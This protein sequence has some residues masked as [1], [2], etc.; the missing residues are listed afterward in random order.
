MS[1]KDNCSGTTDH[2]TLCEWQYIVGTFVPSGVTSQSVEE[3]QAMCS[4]TCPGNLLSFHIS[5]IDTG[6]IWE[7]P[8]DA[9]NFTFYLCRL[10]EA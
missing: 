6:Y 7:A 1:L 2:P 8:L 4:A 5:H 9:V 10:H 3:A